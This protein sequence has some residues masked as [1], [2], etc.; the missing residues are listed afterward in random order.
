MFAF[1]FFFFFTVFFSLPFVLIPHL[2]A[3]CLTL[4]LLLFTKDWLKKI[5]R[6][7]KQN[8]YRDFNIKIVVFGWRCWETS[9]VTWLPQQAL[10][11]LVFVQ[12]HSKSFIS[13]LKWSYV[14]FLIKSQIPNRYYI[15]YIILIFFM[16]LKLITD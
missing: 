8:G 9:K 11:D 2:L 4:L 3:Y 13:I 12:N 16:N 15:E 10:V 7:I 1:F 6:S 14:L 5:Q